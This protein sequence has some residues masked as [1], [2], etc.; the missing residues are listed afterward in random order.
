MNE[1]NK[2]LVGEI[3]SAHGIRGMVKVYPSTDTPER[4]TEIERIY[5]GDELS[6]RRIESSSVQ[7]SM[8][9]LKVE[10]IDDRNASERLRGVKLYIPIED[11][12]PL[13]EGQ[14]FIEDL[15]NLAVYTVG[16]EYIGEVSDVMTQHV[17]DILVIRDGDKEYLIPFVRA[18]VKEVKEDRIV[19]DPIEGM[20]S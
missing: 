8:V 18:F 10:G 14:Y 15:L 13:E 7:K 11:R 5:L 16:D 20:L 6:L 19:V 17:N 3:T 12:K 4:L 2:V 1:K 9:L